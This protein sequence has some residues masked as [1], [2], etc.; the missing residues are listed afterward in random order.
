MPKPKPINKQWVIDFDNPF[1]QLTL[2]RHFKHVK[3]RFHYDMMHFYNEIQFSMA[4]L[5]PVFPTE[6]HTY[7]MDISDLLSLCH[8]ACVEILLH[9]CQPLA[10]YIFK[11]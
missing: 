10:T 5:Y 11:E 8:D 6:M 2:T 7:A 3:V 9:S 1:D 4:T